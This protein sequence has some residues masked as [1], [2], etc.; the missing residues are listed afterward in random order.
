MRGK[1]LDLIS[2]IRFADTFVRDVIAPS[3]LGP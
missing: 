2:T 3:L 1:K